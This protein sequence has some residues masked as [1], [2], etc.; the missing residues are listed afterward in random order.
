M[1][2]SLRYAARTDRGRLRHDNED[3]LYAGPRLLAVAD[4]MGGHVGGEIA[5]RAVIDRLRQLDQARLDGD[6]A[7]ALAEAV[8][9]SNRR[10][11][12]MITDDPDLD[13]MGTTLTALLFDGATLILA[14]VG[15]SRAYRLTDEGLAKITHDD[16]FV[17][18]LVDE[19]QLSE[20]EAATHPQRHMILR[21]LTGL[22]VD[23]ALE[24]L[25]ARVGDRYLVASDG[26]FDVVPAETIAE[27]I[28]AGDLDEAVVALIDH[29]NAAGGPDNISC[30]LAE[31]VDGAGD[32]EPI[33]AGAVAEDPTP[34]A[35][36]G[37]SAAAN[38]P[39]SADEDDPSDADPSTIQTHSDET[40]SDEPDE[41]A[42]PDTETTG[43]DLA[44][45]RGFFARIFRRRPQPDPAAE[46]SQSEAPDRGPDG[47]DGDQARRREEQP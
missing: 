23:V 2:L 33:L 39:E 38:D 47:A 22:E 7:S 14:H 44:P 34:T 5:S 46:T 27:T 19:G 11:R 4:G 37:G 8:H 21:A 3:S 25:S 26:L 6:G 29:A 16:T 12:Q 41:T 32:T 30:V 18:A 15:D 40:G 42:D 36:L 17:Q 28:A 1:T 35:A 31:V 45:R 20:A 43:P 24:E 13:G 9:A 10:L